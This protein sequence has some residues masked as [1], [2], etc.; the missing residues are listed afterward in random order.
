M[1]LIGSVLPPHDT[2]G[3]RYKA[4]PR[5]LRTGVAISIEHQAEIDPRGILGSS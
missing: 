1:P 3:L 5:E 2:S 4:D